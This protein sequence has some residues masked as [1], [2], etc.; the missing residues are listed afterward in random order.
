MVSVLGFNIL[1]QME[2]QEKK[3]E[4]QNGASQ[5]E[6]KEKKV[7]KVSVPVQ[8]T[9]IFKGSM[10]E[11]EIDSAVNTWLKSQTLAG[12]MPMLI[13]L[14]FSKSF[15]RSQLFSINKKMVCGK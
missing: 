4:I 3:A 12:Q 6:P 14:E 8:K 9:F 15:F 2:E 1:I 7:R 10:T 5:E 11:K 13:K